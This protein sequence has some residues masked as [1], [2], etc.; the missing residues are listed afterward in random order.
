M[1]PLPRVVEKG[2]RLPE[3]FVLG[4][5]DDLAQAREDDVGVV[6]HGVHAVCPQL[7]LGHVGPVAHRARPKPA[8]AL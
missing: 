4:S 2:I 5:R 3:Q 8:L 6:D 7:G 1:T